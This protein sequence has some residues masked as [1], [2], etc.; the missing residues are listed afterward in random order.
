MAP[1]D[2]RAP[3]SLGELYD[4]ISILEIKTERISDAQKLVRIRAEL[5][6]LREVAALYPADAQLYA[7]LKEVN[8]KLW[9]VEDAIREE[10]RQ[11]SFGDAFIELARSVYKLNDKRPAT[12]KEINLRSGSAI[13][14][15]KSYT[16]YE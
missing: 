15:V 11:K 6:A 10:E 7:Q 2:V 3:I 8:L 1:I 9:D 16:P 5:S 13:V 4:K 12:K 14:E